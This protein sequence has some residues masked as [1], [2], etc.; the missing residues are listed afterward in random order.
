MS[1]FNETLVDP[2]TGV[3]GNAL[4]DNTWYDPAGNVLKSL[5]AGSQL[6]TKSVY[7]GV[8]RVTA[9]YTGYD[10][11]ETGYADGGDP[12]GPLDRLAEQAADFRL[13]EISA[14]TGRS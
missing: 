5:P 9:Q 4:T 13:V 3:V 14:R 7:D 2:T 8:G 10:L 11:S 1:N 12:H 6:F